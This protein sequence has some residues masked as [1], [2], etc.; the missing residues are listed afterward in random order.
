MTNGML[1]GVLIDPLGRVDRENAAKILN[2]SPKTLSN[3]AIAKRGPRAFRVG[4]RAFYWADEV[5]AF[6][7]GEGKFVPG[8]AHS[9]AHSHD[10]SATE[11]APHIAGA[12][13]SVPSS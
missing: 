3:W 5:A 2:V 4:G 13:R 7:R 12:S 1:P 11:L 8:P 9:G 6:G 10:R